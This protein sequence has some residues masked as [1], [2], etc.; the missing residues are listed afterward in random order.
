MRLI[1]EPALFDFTD[2]TA[3]SRLN[4]GLA[5]HE[6]LRKLWFFAC[7]NIQQVMQD[8]DLAID[9]S[10]GANANHRYIQ[11]FGNLGGQIGWYA[12]E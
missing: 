7:G 3:D 6:I 1:R 2:V 5:L 9:T 8:Q 12:F 10:P 11:G 4:A